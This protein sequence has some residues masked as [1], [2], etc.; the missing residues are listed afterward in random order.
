MEQEAKRVGGLSFGGGRRE[1]FFFSV[2]EYFPEKKRW[3]LKALH[4]VRD[5]ES[6]DRDQILKSWIRTYELKNLVVDFPLTKAPCQESCVVGC[7][8]ADSCPRT[9]VKE[10]REQMLQLLSQDSQAYSDNPKKYEQDRLSSEE[11]DY[12]KNLLHKNSDEHMLSKSFKRKLR[13]GFVPY[14][15]RPIDFWIWKNYYNQLL[16]IFKTSYD[17]YGNVSVMLLSKMS[18]LLR[19]LPPE[20]KMQESSIEICLIELYR[21]K[22]ISKSLL[23]QLTDL[24]L[25]T[26][27]R[28]QVV[29]NIESEL[30]IFMYDTDLDII[31]KNEQAFESF[32]LSVIGQRYLMNSIREIPSWA[33]TSNEKFLIP[34]FHVQG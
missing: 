16:E 20:L 30:D 33:K 22:I 7:Q 14:W 26:L 9:E 24:D 34:T 29:L 15:H 18:Y 1:N 8:G 32:L 10:V 19:H 11:I 21:A 2:L 28:E 5:E 17:S 31:I 3:F 23:M 27:A 4:Q 12:G 6:S 13:K 25:G